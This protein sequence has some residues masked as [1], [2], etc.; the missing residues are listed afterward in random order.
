MAE[1]DTV[2]SVPGEQ[3]SEEIPEIPLSEEPEYAEDY[4]DSGYIADRLDELDDFRDISS[5]L[6]PVD[7]EQGGVIREEKPQKSF[8]KNYNVP[9]EGVLA[10]YPDDKY[11]E[12][13]E[14][15]R[16]AARVLEVTLEEFKISAKVTGIKKGPVITMFEL[17]PAPGV[18]ISKITNLADNIA[19][20]L[21]ASRVRIVAPIPG[22]HAVGIEVPN[23]KRAIV[24]FSEMVSAPEMKD[25]D[26]AVPIVLGKDI[27]GGTQVIDLTRTPH[28]LI[29]GATGSGGC[30]CECSEW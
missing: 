11:S 19:L 6:A 26:V 9:I 10:E 21:A 14:D 29:A 27:R 15:T 22:K 25:P 12:I 30:R 2:L 13:D 28:L 8:H 1:L 4:S 18:K 5:K 16:K 23:K 20:R 24:S 3:I 17:L 7:S